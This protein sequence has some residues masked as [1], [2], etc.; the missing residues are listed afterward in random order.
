MRRVLGR[1]DGW[2]PLCRLQPVRK[3]CIDVFGADLDGLRI[4]SGTS[5]YLCDLVHVQLVRVDFVLL[6]SFHVTHLDLLIPLQQL[7][8]CARPLSA[9]VEEPV[10]ASTVLRV[11]VMLKQVGGFFLYDVAL[12][13]LTF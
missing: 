3:L 9:L 8:T 5:G 12:S 11:L 6:F 2:T 13:L 10:F 4:M 7:I 1:G